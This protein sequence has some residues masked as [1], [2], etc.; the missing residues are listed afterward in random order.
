MSKYAVISF[1][2]ALRREMHKWGVKVSTIEPGPFKTG[3]TFDRNVSQ[4]MDKTWNETN[5]SV[6]KDY[7]QQYFEK[8]RTTLVEFFEL[9]KSV[10]TGVVVNDMLDAIRN[11]KPKISYEPH[12]GFLSILFFRAALHFPNEWFDELTY[13]LNKNKP[14]ISDR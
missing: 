3:M 13:F 4:L 10:D 14:Q 1:S 6:K 5:D 2:D 9:L 7:G 8:Q 11:V 12:K